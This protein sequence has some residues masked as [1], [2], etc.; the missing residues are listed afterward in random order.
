MEPSS[1]TSGV[2]TAVEAAKGGYKLWNWCSKWRYGSIE[3]THPNHR[4]EV[5]GVPW[6]GISGK[7]HNPRGIYW[8]LTRHQVVY[9]PHEHIQLEP[10][11][12]WSGRVKVAEQ[13]EPGPRK[14]FV[15][16][17]WVSE[18]THS[19]FLDFRTRG[20]KTGVWDGI[21][22]RGIPGDQF[23]VLQGS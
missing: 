8:L 15:L 17:S 6:V 12:R 18:Y 4:D 11:G 22:I 3:I 20:R 16:L 2:G 10:D 7:H 21:E 14:S 19:F 5:R 9:W 23:R 1:I 13:A